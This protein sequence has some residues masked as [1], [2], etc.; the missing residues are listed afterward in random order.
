MNG[1]NRTEERAWTRRKQWTAAVAVVACAAV[2][3]GG[4]LAAVGGDGGTDG[5]GTA[6]SSVDSPGA[7]PGGNDIRISASAALWETAGEDYEN[8]YEAIEQSADS[9]RI[10]VTEGG[11]AVMGMGAT[12]DAVAS[13]E[14]A[15]AADDFAT[16]FSAAADAT[17]GAEIPAY[18][19]TNVQT[20]G[21]Q[22][23]DVIKT[24]GTYIYAVNSENLEIVKANDGQPS[25]LAKIPQVLDDGQ[26]YFEMYVVG[27]R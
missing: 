2:A 13:A 20:E 16:E 9:S 10:A 23:A 4:V 3:V 18:S 21:V 8:L 5:G 25:A 26:V 7:V 11:I 14:K 24:D 19:D 27:D 17:S 1:D 15:P 6:V 22:E 12:E